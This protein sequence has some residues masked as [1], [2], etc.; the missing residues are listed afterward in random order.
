M[1]ETTEPGGSV[2]WREPEDKHAAVLLR[3]RRQLIVSNDFGTPD[4][5]K[6]ERYLRDEFL[7]K[8]IG[9]EP[10]AALPFYCTAIDAELAK[11]QEGSDH[12]IE[13]SIEDMTPV[14]YERHCALRLEGAGWTC[15][16]TA[17]SGDQGVDVLAEKDGLRVVLQCKLYSQ[18]VGKSA[19][20]EAIAGKV[21]EKADAAVVVS[22]ATFTRSARSLAENAGVLLLHHDQLADLQQLVEESRSVLD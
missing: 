12:D 4:E 10:P 11:M 22:N 3:R 19:V 1:T 6:W 17:T 18:A 15:R 2:A 21:F 7:A 20:Q 16:M 9:V 5:E 14:E 13:I 8:Q